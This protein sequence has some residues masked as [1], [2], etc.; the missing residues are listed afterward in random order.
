[1]PSRVSGTSP[2]SQPQPSNGERAAPRTSE[3]P[4]GPRHIYRRPENGPAGRPPSLPGS[5]GLAPR[6]GTG[7]AAAASGQSPAGSRQ[8]ALADALPGRMPGA[9]PPGSPG[10]HALN[11]VK[12]GQHPGRVAFA[13]GIDDPAIDSSLKNVAAL[14][15]SS[16]PELREL[17]EKADL[18][19][20]AA[21]PIE[22]AA[23]HGPALAAVRAGE[24]VFAVI[25]RMG[26]SDPDLA[27]PLKNLAVLVRSGD[28][29]QRQFAQN[30]DLSDPAQHQV[31]ERLAAHGPA[32]AAVKAGEPLSAVAQT[33]G[34]S[35]PLLHNDLKNLAALTGSTDPALQRFAQ[36]ADLNDPTVRKDLQKLAAHGPA[37]AAV[38]AGEPLP[39][40]LEHTGISDPLLKNDL[41][42]MAALVH[43]DSAGLRALAQQLRPGFGDPEARHHLARLEG[44]V[45]KH[46]AVQAV[47][48]GEPAAAVFERMGIGQPQ[49]RMQ[50]EAAEQRA[51]AERA[52]AARL[53]NVAALASAGDPAVT[54]RANELL[55]MADGG[56]AAAARRLEEVT[57]RTVAA[58]AM[59]GGESVSSAANRMGISSPDLR[60]E[61]ETRHREGQNQVPLAFRRGQRLPPIIE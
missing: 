57:A 23:A 44:V 40:V 17:A 2:S 16:D 24:P 26:I 32:A 22:Y 56:S 60:A 52:H 14:M 4:A 5:A 19:P 41:K 50:L 51:P 9:S 3:Y 46:L 25:E 48:G 30:A 43:S 53:K 29:A 1:M 35:D 55:Q 13:L 47:L 15:R 11:A 6:T 39:A 34:I 12:A 38:K 10:Q 49:H 59:R 21:Y 61:L 54:A 37:M 45:V 28:P 58:D 8:R 20:D 36:N 42:N 33:M 7:V 27:A 18:H 31:L